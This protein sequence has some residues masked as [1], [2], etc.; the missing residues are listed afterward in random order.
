MRWMSTLEILKVMQSRDEH[1]SLYLFLLINSALDWMT[2]NAFELGASLVYH[3]TATVL[4]GEGLSRNP[5][6]IES[7]IEYS[8]S[9]LMSGFVWPIRP[10]GPQTVRDWMYWLCTWRL[11]RDINRTL[12]HLIPVIDRRIELVAAKSPD[13][14]MDMI[15]GLVES[16]VPTPEEGS[17]LRHAHRVLHITFAASAVSSALVLHTLHQTL[18][19]PEHLEPLRKEIADA[20]TQYGGWTENAMLNMPF[21]DSYLREMLRLYPPSICK[22]RSILPSCWHTS[23][24][25]ANCQPRIV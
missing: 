5:K 3:V 25:R 15:Q 1:P 11:R 13:R 8:K 24:S 21:L 4:V 12:K 23:P 22:H 18:I 17:P 6:Y 7:V 16:E 14:P 20:V 19:T 9:F 2:F 10:F